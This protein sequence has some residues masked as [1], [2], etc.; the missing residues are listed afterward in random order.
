MAFAEPQSG[1]TGGPG[2][3]GTVS[4]TVEEAPNSRPSEASAGRM[5]DFFIIGHQ[6]CGTTALYLMLKEHPQI[7]LPEY[8]E[9]RFFAPELRPLPERETPDRPQTLERYLALFAGAGAHQRA[10]EASP[11]YIRSPTAAARIAELQPDARIIAL[12]REPASFLRSYHMEMVANHVETEGSFRKAIEL[13]G[14]R[15]LAGA[16]GSFVRPQFLYSD[17][18]R[19]VEQLR[20]FHVSF[21]RERVLTLIY[22]DF[23]RDNEATVRDVQRFLDVDDT[24][25][26]QQVETEPLNAVRSMRLHQFRRAIGRADTNPT[27][28]SPLTRGLV[29]LTPGKLR[30]GPISNVFRR[31]AYATPRPPDEAFMLELRHRFKGEVEALSDYLGRDLVTLWHYD[32]IA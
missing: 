4:G 19:Y 10:G 28:A 14:R 18:V 31:V 11:Q 1:G 20:R 25:P 26:L 17:H 22:D 13:E 9:P 5:P 29:A 7:F 30:G 8:K 2:G 6:K 16:D 27:A 12:L 15:R 32:K 21:P 3:G 24:A 23:R